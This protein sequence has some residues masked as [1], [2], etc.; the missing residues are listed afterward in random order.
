MLDVVV[1]TVV[2]EVVVGHEAVN[3]IGTEFWVA[4]LNDP[5]LGL[6]L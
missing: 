6:G 1:V 3:E 4:V 2:V 5:E